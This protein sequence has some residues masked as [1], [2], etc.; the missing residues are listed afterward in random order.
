MLLA[1]RRESEHHHH[2]TVPSVTAAATATAAIAP[3]PPATVAETNAAATNGLSLPTSSIT[4]SDSLNTP[5][6]PLLNLCRSPLHFTAPPPLPPPISVQPGPPQ[7]GFYA[8]TPS[9]ASSY[10]QH[11]THAPPT[12]A[13]SSVSCSSSLSSSNNTASNGCYTATSDNCRSTAP[14]AEELEEFVDIFQVQHLLLDHS[15][16]NGNQPP[17]P[18]NLMS[19]SCTT[20]VTTTSSAANSS[21][22]QAT[23]TTSTTLAS[24]TNIAKP[25]PR[26][27]LNLQKASE[28]AAQHQ[29]K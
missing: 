16:A 11:Y 7:F 21:E 5:S 8:P 4:N 18:H 29:G 1:M 6:T 2:T 25:Q 17:P 26:P 24:A 10:F 15:V 23:A 9:A 28:Y 27:R 22:S 3:S 19:T 13:T 14:P 20:S 12:Y